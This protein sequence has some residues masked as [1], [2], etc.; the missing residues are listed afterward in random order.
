[1][2]SAGHRRTLHPTIAA[3]VWSDAPSVLPPDKA[4]PPEAPVRHGR[5]PFVVGAVP[6]SREGWIRRRRFSRCAGDVYSPWEDW[7][8][9]GRFL[10]V[11]GDSQSSRESLPRC[12]RASELR[13]CPRECVRVREAVAAHSCGESCSPRTWAAAPFCCSDHHSRL[14]THIDRTL[15]AWKWIP[16]FTGMTEL[17]AGTTDRSA[18]MSTQAKRLCH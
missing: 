13:Y 5:L 17:G 18:G 7:K 12:G 9:R 2:R 4:P 14:S 16:V 11:A 15:P 3:R 8:R 1:M 6:A 10:L